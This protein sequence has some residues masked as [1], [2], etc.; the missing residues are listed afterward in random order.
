MVTSLKIFIP[1]EFFVETFSNTRLRICRRIAIR[2]MYN[3]L[4]RLI[5]VRVLILT[6]VLI[7]LLT[8]LKTPHFGET[9]SLV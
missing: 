1:N 4:P 8:P 3:T 6:N 7:E 9:T 2:S 5:A